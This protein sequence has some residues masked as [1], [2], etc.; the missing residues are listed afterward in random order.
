[1]V[2]LCSISRN[3]RFEIARLQINWAQKSTFEHVSLCPWDSGVGFS[4]SKLSF[5]SSCYGSK[6]KLI[7][8]TKI[9]SRK[10]LWYCG[11]YILAFV[12]MSHVELDF[13][14]GDMINKSLLHSHLCNIGLVHLE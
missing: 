4:I 1:M 10:N 7:V 14:G 3:R 2:R 8:S 5:Q 12:V 11:V 9:K 13:S 6:Y